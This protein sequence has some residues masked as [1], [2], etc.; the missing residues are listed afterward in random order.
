MKKSRGLRN[1]NPGNIRLGNPRFQGEVTGT[2]RSFRC[3]STMAWG[4]RAL[5]KTL[6]TYQTRHGLKTIRQMISRWAPTNENNTAAYVAAVCRKTGIGGDTVISMFN[7]A[8]AVKM[9]MAISEV[10]NG[11]K[12]E[13]S[14][15]EEGWRLV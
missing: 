1:N 15:V 13:R 8:T 3:F 6:Q 12:A 5:I 14:A 7:E 2:D 4:Y 11:V 9:A 10:E